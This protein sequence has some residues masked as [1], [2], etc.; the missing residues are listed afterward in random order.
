MTPY[1]E[2][3][4]AWRKA[5]GGQVE[6]EVTV[7]VGAEAEVGLPGKPSTTVGSGRHRLTLQ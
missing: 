6:V 7:P 5:A 1:G 2:A 3:A 4:V